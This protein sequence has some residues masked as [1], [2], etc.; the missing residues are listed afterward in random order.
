MYWHF[1]VWSERCCWHKEKMQIGIQSDRSLFNSTFCFFSRLDSAYMLFPLCQ[2]I[3]NQAW[4]CRS[5]SWKA[6]LCQSCPLFCSMTIWAML[7]I[8]IKC[9]SRV[10][11][12]WR[13]T[14]IVYA[15]RVY[16]NST[17]ALA[18]NGG[19]RRK[20]HATEHYFFSL[21]AN[22]LCAARN[23]SMNA[24]YIMCAYY[25]WQINEKRAK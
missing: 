9:T 8:I 19:T 1:C 6:R 15:L 24:N 14:N 12:T 2:F 16:S 3:S 21:F 5:G 4:W 11:K 23:C 13:R 17:E 22:K 7:I 10:E 25:T 20:L 18:T